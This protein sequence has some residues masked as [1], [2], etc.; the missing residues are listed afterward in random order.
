MNQLLLISMSPPGL[1]GPDAHN[2]NVIAAIDLYRTERL[3]YRSSRRVLSPVVALWPINRVMTMTSLGQRGRLSKTSFATGTAE[4][5][6]G[7]PA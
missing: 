4:N 7:H 6:F 1:C 5:A 3:V 2:G